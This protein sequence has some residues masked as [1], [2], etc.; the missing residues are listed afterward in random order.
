MFTNPLS[1]SES[2]CGVQLNGTFASNITNAH[3]SVNITTHF[4]KDNRTG[5]MH[6]EDAF[7]GWADV[8]Q[9]GKKQE[10]PRKGRATVEATTALVG[11]WIPEVYSFSLLLKGIQTLFKR[12]EISTTTN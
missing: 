8:V 2:Y 6:I 3:L 5:G 11:G 12:R 9:D 10:V 7:K 1:R 4:Y